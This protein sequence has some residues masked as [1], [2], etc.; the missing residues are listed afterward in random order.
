MNVAMV[1][2]GLQIG[3]IERVGSDYVKLLRQLG[4]DVTIINLVPELDEMVKEFPQDCANTVVKYPRWLAPERYAKLVK[5]NAVGRFLYPMAFVVCCLM[6]LLYRCVC[7]FRPQFR[8]QYDLAIAFSGHYNDLTFVANKFVKA[9]HKMA[10]LHGA[11]YGY[12]LG[13]DGYFNLYK[14]IKNLVVL[15]DDAQEQVFCCNNCCQLNIHKLYN[16]V[17]IKEKAIDDQIVKEL[18]DKYGNFLLMVS[19]F[20]YPHKDQFTV[21]AALKVCREKYGDELNLVFVG[22]G[23]DRKRVEEYVHSLGEEVSC[24]TFFEGSRMDVENY[25]AAAYMLVHA[26][27]AGEGLP[28]VMLEAMALDLPMVVTDSKT[29]PREILGNDKYGLLCKIKDPKDMAEK[30]HYM[31]SDKNVYE[32]YQREGKK[33]LDAFT[34]DTIRKHLKS[35]LEDVC[36]KTSDGK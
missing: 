27:V 12:L 3:G 24:H 30:I 28:T 31:Y 1:F 10:W 15:V 25:Y 17:F 35:V 36:S 5:V 33:R 14:K 34:P 20:Q 18:K 22:D 13:S 26:S 9:K 6:N 16:P 4:H 21:A 32:H 7:R 2:D 19:R 23:P 8:K 11:L 29:G